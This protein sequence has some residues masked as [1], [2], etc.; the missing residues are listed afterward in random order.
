MVRSLQQIQPCILMKFKF[1]AVLVSAFTK[2]GDVEAP[3]DVVGGEDISP[4][5]PGEGSVENDAPVEATK[6]AEPDE[7][8]GSL[9]AVPSDDSA[10]SCL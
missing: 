2:S 6:S 5:T 9:E 8:S 3:S 10:L 1:S 4:E 7:G